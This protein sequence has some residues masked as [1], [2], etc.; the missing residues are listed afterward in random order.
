MLGI[1]EYHYGK[2]VELGTCTSFEMTLSAMNLGTVFY[3]LGIKLENTSSERP[4]LKRR[5]KFR[6]NHKH[7]EFVDI[8]D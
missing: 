5:N 8:D 4:K 2:G 7:F 3:D 6:V 1:Y